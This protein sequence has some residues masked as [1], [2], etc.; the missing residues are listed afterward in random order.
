MMSCRSCLLDVWSATARNK[1][2][3]ELDLRTVASML[4]GGQSGSAVV[5]GKPD[6][7]LILQKVLAKDMPPP[8]QIIKAG[9]R[10]MESSEISLL[11]TWIKQGAKEYDI[12]PQCANEET[13][14][15]RDR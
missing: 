6:E 4:K 11:T 9:V 2:E 10:P 3:G 8:K 7:S 12:T 5:P 1:Q 14:S 15:S 13:G